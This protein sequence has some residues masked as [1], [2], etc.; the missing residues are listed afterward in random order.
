MS[1]PAGGSSSSFS[2]AVAAWPVSPWGLV[3]HHHAAVAFDDW[4]IKEVGQV[5]D[6]V[7]TAG[8]PGIN[9]EIAAP[10]RIWLREALAAV[11]L[12]A[13]F[14]SAGVSVPAVERLGDQPGGGGFASAPR[15]R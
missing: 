8:A 7:D 12:A 2:E 11:A 1:V 15:G 14:S 5:T 3:N 6:G 9:L 10:L 4:L 13:R